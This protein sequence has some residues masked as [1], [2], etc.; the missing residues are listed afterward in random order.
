MTL[1]AVF[2]E[3][4]NGALAGIIPTPRSD[5][6]LSF[7]DGY[8]HLPS[9][10]RQID[11]QRYFPRMR[12]YGADGEIPLSWFTIKGEG[13]YFSSSTAQTDEYLLYVIQLERDAGDWGFMGGYGGEEVT[14]SRGQTSFAPDRGLSRAFLGRASYDIDSKRNI[15]LDTAIRQNGEGVC[16]L[17]WNIPRC[18]DLIVAER[19]ALPF[20]V[21]IRAISSVSIARIHFSAWLCDTASN[22]EMAWPPV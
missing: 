4:R 11:F 12:M 20:C 13:A 6:S 14:A 7:F 21:A 10:D 17:G 22:P 8:N 3:D 19:S 9:Y 5:T 1:G 15:S 16:S 18:G 2:P